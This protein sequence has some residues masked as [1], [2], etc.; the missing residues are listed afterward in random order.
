MF[1]EKYFDTFSIRVLILTFW[2][3]CGGFKISKAVI[4]VNY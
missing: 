4:F 1:Y 2:Y 3:W